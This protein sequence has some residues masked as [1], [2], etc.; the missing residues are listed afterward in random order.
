MEKVWSIFEEMIKTE[1]FKEHDA[2]TA[3]TSWKAFDD[4]KKRQDPAQ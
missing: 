2:L 3:D 1:Q 4:W